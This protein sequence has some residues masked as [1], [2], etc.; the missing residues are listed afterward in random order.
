MIPAVTDLVIV[1]WVLD[2]T[3]RV[4]VLNKITAMHQ[5]IVHAQEQEIFLR[6]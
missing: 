6:W 4:C 2:W 3:A 5:R 1:N